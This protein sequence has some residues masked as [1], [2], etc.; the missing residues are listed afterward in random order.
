MGGHK[1]DGLWGDQLSSGEKIAFIF[2]VFI[3][4]YNNYLPLTDIGNG[5]F[6]GIELN[7][8]VFGGHHSSESFFFL[9]KM[10]FI[11][12]NIFPNPNNPLSAV[13]LLVKD[14][15]KGNMI[16]VESQAPRAG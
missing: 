4:N 8:F 14:T 12:S 5:F 7:F 11:P 15:P 16:K 10:D 9:L 3:I 13:A 6:Y 2:P 1:I